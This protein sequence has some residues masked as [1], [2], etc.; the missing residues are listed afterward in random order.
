MDCSILHGAF[1]LYFSSNEVM[2]V[3]IWSSETGDC[4]LGQFLKICFVE[5]GK[6]I[7]D[8][9]MWVSI[10]PFKVTSFVNLL[11]II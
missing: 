9:E 4:W 8:K 7:L 3:M 5:W 2:N 1:L 10:A 6:V 11:S